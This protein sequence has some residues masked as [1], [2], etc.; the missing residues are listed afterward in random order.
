ML[1]DGAFSEE[2]SG[3]EVV[4][5]IS[6][7][8]TALIIILNSQIVLMMTHTVAAE[9]NRRIKFNSSSGLN[10]TSTQVKLSFIPGIFLCTDPQ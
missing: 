1:R 4:L 9:M 5:F 6:N 10:S 8:K 3:H 7:L 2:N